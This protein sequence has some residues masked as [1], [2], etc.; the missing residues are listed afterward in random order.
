MKITYKNRSIEKV[1]TIASVAEKKYGREMAEKIQMRIDQLGA[2]DTIEDLVKYRIGRCHFLKGD[3]KG[4]Y[5]MDLI[6][7]YRLIF[8]K[9]GEEIQIANVMEIVDYH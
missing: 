6:H 8:V 2:T 9:T 5:A 7:P 1:C 3:R 4:Q